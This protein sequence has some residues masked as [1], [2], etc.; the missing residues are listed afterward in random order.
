M[1]KTRFFIFLL[2]LPAGIFAQKQI[3][4]IDD[5]L[6]VSK[7]YVVA[8][9]VIIPECD[10][11]TVQQAWVKVLQANTRSKAVVQSGE[12]SIFGARAKDLRTEPFNVYSRLLDQDSAIYL[13]A[14][15]ELTKDIYV[16]RVTTPEEYARAKS[17]LQQFAIEQYTKLAKDQLDAE[18][19]KLRDL[20]KELAKLENDHDRMLRSIESNNASIAS[21]KSNISLQTNEL[22]LVTSNLSEQNGLLASLGEGPAKKE[23]SDEIKDLEKRKKKA[24][25]SI[26]SSQKKIKNSQKEIEEA[27]AAIPANETS[28][29]DVRKKIAAQQEVY[30]KFA[31]K[32]KKIKAY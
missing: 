26:E 20:E 23:K 10:F 8:L 7:T 30:E 15:F 27:K 14:A 3:N 19:K 16:E 31:G 18:D 12:I 24:Q 5:S 25:N 22:N 13:A 9:S 32:Y 2:L 11:T 29:D 1:K 4:V 28:Q 6:M 21:E 17:L